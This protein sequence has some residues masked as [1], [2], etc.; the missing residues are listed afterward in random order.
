[1]TVREKH[2]SDC[3]CDE[4]IERKWGMYEDL[5][6]GQVKSTQDVLMACSRRYSRDWRHLTTRAHATE[7]PSRARDVEHGQPRKEA[8]TEDTL[9]LDNGRR[10]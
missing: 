8:W 10:M 9:T 2:C 3:D 4:E 5:A 6:M 1:M 7:H